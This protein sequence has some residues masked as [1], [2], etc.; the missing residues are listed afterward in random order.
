MWK[1]IVLG[2]LIVAMVGVLV[3]GAVNR[4]VAKT[5]NYQA[6]GSG[7]R[8]GHSQL[9]LQTTA[10]LD[11]TVIGLNNHANSEAEHRHQGANDQRPFSG[12]RRGRPDWAGLGH[13]EP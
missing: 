10:P 11:D 12:T 8:R 13:S 1:R 9:D 6:Q 7:Y 2:T 4:T 5:G 3:L